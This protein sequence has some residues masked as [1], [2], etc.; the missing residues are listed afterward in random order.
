MSVPRVVPRRRVQGRRSGGE[1]REGEARSGCRRRS[2]PGVLAIEQL[3][4]L[5]VDDDVVAL[6]R[7]RPPPGETMVV[8][9]AARAPRCGVEKTAFFDLLRLRSRSRRGSSFRPASPSTDHVDDRDGD[10]GAVGGFGPRHRPGRDCRSRSRAS[11]PVRLD[12]AYTILPT[13]VAAEPTTLTVDEAVGRFD[14]V[15]Q[16][17]EDDRVV[18]RRADERLRRLHGEH[19][20]SSPA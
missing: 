12:D 19:R 14:A 15:R 1:S 20:P 10:S 7:S 2:R 6:E 11:P 3:A 18:V 5:R 13:P 8:L 16:L 4:R 17:P 9:Y